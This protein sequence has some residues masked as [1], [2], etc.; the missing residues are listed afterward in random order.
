MRLNQNRMPVSEIKKSAIHAPRLVSIIDKLVTISIAAF[1]AG[2]AFP[3]WCGDPGTIDW[4]MELLLGLT[5][6]L[7]Y[8]ASIFF[9]NRIEK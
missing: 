7:L 5:A 4:R 1:V 9:Q 2:I 3:H 8:Y 6:V